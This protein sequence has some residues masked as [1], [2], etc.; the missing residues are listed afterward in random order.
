MK[1][2]IALPIAERLRA[3]LLPHCERCEIAGSIRRKKP[4]VGDIEIVLIP[5][6]YDV[7]LFTSGIA[8]VLDR[9]PVVKG[10]LPCRYA[11]RTLPEGIAVDVFIV[12]PET[13]GL[14]FAVRTGSADFA[15]NVLACGWVKQGYKSID[16]LL[17]RNGV[18]RECRE[19]M[20]LFRMAG[21]QW[22]EPE[23]RT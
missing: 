21:V 2:T 19:E 14:Q 22:V 17:T 20:D 6:P 9:Y 10:H 3:E 13:W 12:R 8:A 7:G 16:G 23:K 4:E 11:Q 1:Y 18:A 15:H 5:R